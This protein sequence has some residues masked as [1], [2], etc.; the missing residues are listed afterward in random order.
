M[1]FMVMHKVDAKMEAGEPPSQQIIGDLPYH[2]PR[3]YLRQPLWR[4]LGASAFLGRSYSATYSR[5][6][7]KYVAGSLG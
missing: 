3:Y 5:A 4:R 6:E 1:R 7:K 2:L